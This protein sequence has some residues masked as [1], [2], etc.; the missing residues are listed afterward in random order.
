MRFCKILAVT[1]LVL[2]PGLAQ[3]VGFGLNVRP[4]FRTEITPLQNGIYEVKAIGSSAA[5]NYWCGIGDYAIRTLGVSNSQRIYIARAYEP[6]VR[7]VQFSLTP[8]PG[9]DTNPG[10]SI[11]VKRVG[12]NMSASSA[13]NYCYDNFMDLDF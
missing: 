5:I 11:T 2:T 13:Q 3:A 8:P 4:Q 6:G 9:A 7:T 1:A 12:E 10:Y